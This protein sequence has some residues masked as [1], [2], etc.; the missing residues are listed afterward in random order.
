M[1]ECILRYI[2]SLQRRKGSQTMEYIVIIAVGALFATILLNAIQSETIQAAV[3]EKVR[4]FILFSG[5]GC[6]DPQ[7]ASEN[8]KPTV[9]N[10]P[11]DEHKNP[12]S[13]PI[14]PVP[15]QPQ[16]QV[17]SQEQDLIEPW[18]KCLFS[19]YCLKK[20]AGEAVDEI[21]SFFVRYMEDLEKEALQHCGQDAECI[22]KYKLKKGFSL[23]L[24]LQPGLGLPS[25]AIEK[26]TGWSFLDTV[27]DYTVEHPFEALATVLFLVSIPFT[28]GATG[29]AG[30]A[31]V[32]ATESVLGGLGAA[33]IA[34]LGRRLSIRFFPR[35][36]RWLVRR[37]PLPRWV[38]RFLPISM[39]GGFTASAESSWFDWI[40]DGKVNWKKALVNGILGVAIG[41][42]APYVM[43][44]IGTGLQQIRHLPV[45]FEITPEGSI[46]AKR[47]GDT[48]IGQK[49]QDAGDVL[50]R[51]AGSG[52]QVGTI[53]KLHPNAGKVKP[54]TNKNGK[55]V[56]KVR[57]WD[58]EWVTLINGTKKKVEVTLV[59]GTKVIVPFK[60]GFPDF[61]QW[62]KA[63]LTLPEELWFKRDR[64]QLVFEQKIVREGNERS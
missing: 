2:Q 16:V 63:E 23:A 24:H 35:I 38:S 31:G 19:L 15:P 62:T 44:G 27:A 12:D 59:D 48:G 55:I 25:L 51:F 49:L 37:I 13:P 52:D 1:R 30:A 60:K 3:I 53:P 45:A 18:Y 34:Y 14:P 5:E 36:S 39:E 50:R 64:V 47:L 28:G 32:G 10:Y 9:N 29:V 58:G 43:D 40:R 56:N 61:T 21:K 7:S 54:F 33:G 17:T 20:N 11:P 26:L 57:T 4:C 8:V 6:K 22:S 41:F 46:L 42:G